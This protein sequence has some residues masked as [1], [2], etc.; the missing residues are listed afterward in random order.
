MVTKTYYCG[1]LGKVSVY[2]HTLASWFDVSIANAKTLYDVMCFPSNPD[3]VVTV[4][5]VGG[6]GDLIWVGT[7]VANVVTWNA[8]TI[9]MVSGSIAALNEV[10]VTDD[11]N[12]FAIG[13][14]NA[15]AGPV[16]IRSIDG[17]LT[18]NEIPLNLGGSTGWALHFP[19]PTL[20]V[21]A[22]N[23]SVY[24]TTNGGI[25]WIPTNGGNNL[26]LNFAGVGGIAWIK[27]INIYEQSTG[28]YRIT[29]L[30]SNGVAQSIDS[31]VTFVKRFDYD[32]V[33]SVTRIGEHLTWYGSNTFWATDTSGGLLC[34]EDGGVNWVIAL[35][36]NN[37]PVDSLNGAHFYR[38]SGTGTS[39]L[40][41][42]YTEYE[43]FYAANFNSLGY[44]VTQQASSKVALLYPSN[45]SNLPAGETAANPP[46]FFY[47]VWTEVQLDT[48]IRL[49]ECNGTKE[50]II[51]DIYS[52]P[53]GKLLSDFGVGNSVV[54]DWTNLAIP[55]PCLLVTTNYPAIC[56][57]IEEII[58]DC[59]VVFPGNQICIE[60]LP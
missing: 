15:Q 37:Q 5:E 42:P 10:W 53:A 46:D 6:L 29:A 27:G 17:G 45:I 26:N 7:N 36:V 31:G 55:S 39:T 58:E 35:P 59:I 41:Q 18:F 40:G 43:G 60:V 21:I 47:A 12:I 3:K 51:K 30:T 9:T 22:I 1:D 25:T 11:N 24:Y 44:S 33:A 20:G 49:K 14:K 19:T 32:T 48:C 28:S 2:D 57:T 34:S 50:I 4:G 52:A 23:T 8:P 38:I 54:L 16:L 56:W 13:R